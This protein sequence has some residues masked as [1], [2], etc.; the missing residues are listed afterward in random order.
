MRV[1]CLAEKKRR[2]REEDTEES[3]GIVSQMSPFLL[4]FGPVQPL[5]EVKDPRKDAVHVILAIH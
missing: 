5:T 4:H 3:V 1:K 2:G